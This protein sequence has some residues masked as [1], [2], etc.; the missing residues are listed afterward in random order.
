MLLF[1]FLFGL[2]LGAETPSGDHQLKLQR[3][4]CPMFWFSFNGRCYKYVAS[5]MTWAD[6]D[7]HCVSESATLVSIHCLE[8]ER[9][10]TSLIKNFDPAQGSTWIGFSDI[11]KEGRWIW[12]DG[13]ALDF[14]FW[15]NGQPNNYHGKEHCAR[16]NYNGNLKWNDGPCSETLPFVCASRVCP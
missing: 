10:V 1:L 14:A 6:A 4:N 3:G 2:A 5:H 7:F 11:H 12:S 15:D 16:K 8:E 9:F 13:S